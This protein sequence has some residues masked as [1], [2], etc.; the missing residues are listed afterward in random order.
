MSKNGTHE[1]LHSCFYYY[2]ELKL[3]K[4]EKISR[5][6]PHQ[7]NRRPRGPSILLENSF[8]DD[9]VVIT[10]ISFR[11]R[12]KTTLTSFWHFWPP[13]PL[14]WHFLPYKRWQKS[15]FIDYLPV[16]PSSCKR[17]LWTTPYPKCATQMVSNFYTLSPAPVELRCE[18][19]HFAAEPYH[20]ANKNCSQLNKAKNKY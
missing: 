11:G 14:R 10:Y 8:D 12:S 7:A 1:T 5:F 9:L 17:C 16:P 6:L 19:E 13:T 4:T 3:G 20:M 15:T 18:D 2:S